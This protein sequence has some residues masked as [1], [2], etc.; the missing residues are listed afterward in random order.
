MN[1]RK[2]RI[3][4]WK[5][6]LEVRQNKSVLAS[7]IIV[8]LVIMVVLPAVMLVVVN[9]TGS[10]D[11]LNDPDLQM[12]FERIPASIS[13]MFGDL[14]D[15]QMTITMILGFLFAP[16][17]LIMPL[18][19]A[20]TI[21]A[22]SFAGEKERKTLEAVLYSPATDTEL[23][24]GKLLAAWIPA[25]I[26]ALGSFLLYGLIANVAAWQT[27]QHI[28][29]PNWM[30]VILVL[31]VAP[32]AAAF[33]LG[34]MILVSSRARTFQDASQIGGVVVLP[35]VL[36]VLG[37]IGGVIALSGW[38]VLLIGAVLWMIDCAVIFLAIRTFKRE[39]VVT[40]L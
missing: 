27:M 4:T 36:L 3:I 31:W 13:N 22:N 12:M 26:V 5:D 28:F 25:V 20:S 7:M 16:M 34:I 6:I 10:A 32:A 39:A 35:V 23:F 9:T 8:P 30:W 19:V 18:M 2:I 38:V 40:K 15:T 24:I 17:F 37:Q 14:N 33:G 1:W 21:A 29:F 11:V